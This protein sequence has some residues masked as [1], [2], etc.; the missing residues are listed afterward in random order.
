[1]M[2]SKL[3]SSILL[4]TV[5]AA[6]LFVFGGFSRAAFGPG[7]FPQQSTSPTVDGA[8]AQQPAMVRNGQPG[9]MHRRLDALVG[10][11]D[12]V[13]TFYI[14]GG[15][16]AKPLVANG[17]TCRREWIAETGNKHLR[18]VT[19]GTVGGNR[20]YRLGILSYST[21][22]K[23]YEWN[24]VDALNTMMMTY[25]GAPGSAGATD[26]IVMS[27]EFTDQ[28]VLGDDYAGKRIGQ[29]TVI[30][31]ESPDRQVFELYLTPPGERERLASRA[32]YARRK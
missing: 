8:Q 4:G 17:M 11:W 23:S 28:G 14:A 6:L 21:M 2:K 22:D 20:Y 29:R 26:N 1:M 7:N 25:K 13:M 15:T 19:T 12:V 16:S 27:G 31:I 32:E 10:E 3:T 5:S 9:A 18:D 24:T 30:K